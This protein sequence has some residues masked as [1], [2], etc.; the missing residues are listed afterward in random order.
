MTAANASK[1]NDGASMILMMNEFGL[2]ETKM[3][4]CF[5]IVGYADA[6]VEPS[7]FNI[8]PNVAIKKAL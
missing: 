8:A 6:E 7:D 1:L 2:K 4:P 3:E 5:E